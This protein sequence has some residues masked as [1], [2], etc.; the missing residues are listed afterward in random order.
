M[1]GTLKNGIDCWHYAH[2][3]RGGKEWEVQI[4][5]AI[6][7]H[8]KL[9]LICSRRSIYRRNVVSEIMRAIDE[10]RRTGEQK[11]F[12]I[13]LDDHI[14]GTEILEEAREKVKSG[15]WSENWVFYVQKYHI[16]DFS[17]WTDSKDYQR[18][19]TKLI[20]DLRNPVRRKVI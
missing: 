11:L 15:E 7:E 1:G 14:L 20:Q 18:E 17:R 9:I 5:D 6:K 4:T 16:P 3:M 10:E 13:R 19:L 2:D 8:R 12:P